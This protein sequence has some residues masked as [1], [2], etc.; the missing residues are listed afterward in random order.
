[1]KVRLIRNIYHHSPETG[2]NN[3]EVYKDYDWEVAPVVGMT[4]DDSA[5]HRNDCTKIEEIHVT[6][7]EGDIY[8]VTLNSLK[9]EHIV[10]VERYVEIA[11]SHDWDTM[12]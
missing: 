10:Q 6:A 11:K 12:Y 8:Y 9:V 3:K 4:V 2:L 5:W 1:M 7:D